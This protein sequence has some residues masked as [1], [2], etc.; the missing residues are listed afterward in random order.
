MGQLTGGGT[1]GFGQ[2]ARDDDSFFRKG[3][4][5]GYNYTLGSKITH[6][7]HVGYQRYNDG[8]DRFQT[9][10]GWG[11]ITIPAGVGTA[12]TC[13][14]SV[15]GTATPAFFVAT[16]QQ[17]TAGVPTIHSEFHS[18]NVELN[19][20]IHWNNW[21]FNV[22]VLA[23]NDTLYGQGLAK[24]D[25]IAGFVKS[26]GTKY[27]MHEFGFSD[28]IQPRLGATWAYNGRD[29]VWAS[30]ARYNP[31]ANSDARA[32][33][34]DR[35]LVDDD[36]RLLRRDRKADRRGAERILVRQ[37]V[38]GRNQ[39]AR[40]QGVHDRNGAADDEP[41]VGPSLR[42]LS[43]G[44]PLHGRH[45][46]HGAKR[47]QRAG[48]HSAGAVRAEPRHGPESP[49]GHGLRG[50]IGSGSTYVIANLDGAFTKYYEATVE[51]EWRGNSLILN[52]SYTWSH[53]YGN[54]DQ[55]NSSFSTPTTPR[56][57]SGRR[58]SATAPDAS[59]GTTSTVIFA[60]TAATS[61]SS[62]ARTVAV[63]RDHRRVLRLSV[64]PAVSARERAAVPPADRFDER[65]EP[66]RRAGRLAQNAVT[67]STRSELHAELPV[68][69]RS[70]PSARVRRLQCD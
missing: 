58:T 4:Q 41:L 62:T 15:C 38:A 48:R 28:M 43:P 34:W 32:A 21:S 45:E 68:G 46:Q 23:S 11:S 64:G 57:S 55:D 67:T 59:S 35:N 16:F 25:N 37:V 56:S 51:Q 26:P 7:L 27:K 8:E 3:G 65:H 29:T 18:Q 17:Q 70:Q 30:Y 63:A 10:N 42:A 14:A 19:D 69:A 13:P 44:R 39:A 24:A 1:V 6:D 53:Y 47:L 31:A 2:F 61:S 5:I 49:G 9:S 50:A 20:T 52:G 66:L 40:D 36:Q 33:S 54:F 22:G 12:G 60:A